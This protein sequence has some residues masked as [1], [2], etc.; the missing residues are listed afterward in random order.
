MTCKDLCTTAPHEISEGTTKTK[1]VIDNTLVCQGT[2]ATALMGLGLHGTFDVWPWHTWVMANMGQ[3]WSRFNRFSSRPRS[4]A[5]LQPQ[6]NKGVLSASNYVNAVH[7]RHPALRC[8]GGNLNQKQKCVS[9]NICRNR[10]HST[11]HSF[12]SH[13][14]GTHNS[15]LN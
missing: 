4:W 6:K 11:F 9:T 1:H 2:W 3:A 5:M 8:D 12:L 14:L 10:R 7:P 15:I 13:Y